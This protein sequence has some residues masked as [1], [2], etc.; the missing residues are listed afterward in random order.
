[1]LELLHTPSKEGLR[2]G[3]LYQQVVRR[4]HSTRGAG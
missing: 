3:G 4:Y 2:K 1:L